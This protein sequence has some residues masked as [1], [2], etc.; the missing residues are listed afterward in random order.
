M[1]LRWLATGLGEPK[2][3]FDNPQLVIN[4]DEFGL[5][6]PTPKQPA[7]QP[8]RLFQSTFVVGG[9][10]RGW[11]RRWATLRSNNGRAARPGRG[12]VGVSRRVE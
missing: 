12:P 4:P 7:Q 5:S 3:D 6:T 2:L 9:R 1:A 10:E 11:L 8:A